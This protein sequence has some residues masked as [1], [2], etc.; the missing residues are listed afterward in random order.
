VLTVFRAFR[1]FTKIHGDGAFPGDVG[2]EGGRAQMFQMFAV[3]GGSHRLRLWPENDGMRTVERAERDA[4]I[5]RG[6]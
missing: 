1:I 6:L 3:T 5:F 4:G 2:I